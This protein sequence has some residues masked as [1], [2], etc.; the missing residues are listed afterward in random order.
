[1]RETEFC[2]T[3]MMQT[4][5]HGQDSCQ[6]MWQRFAD[7]NHIATRVKCSQSQCFKHWA[8]CPEHKTSNRS[9]YEERTARCAWQFPPMPPGVQENAINHFRDQQEPIKPPSNVTTPQLDMPSSPN[10]TVE[11][12]HYF[13]NQQQREAHN[14]PHITVP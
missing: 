10:I 1:M 14:Q 2:P 12:A 6:A 4:R 8:M 7:T 3:C 9:K 5:L 11:H 13:Q